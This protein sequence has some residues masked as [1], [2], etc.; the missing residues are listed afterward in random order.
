MLNGAMGI[1]FCDA[2]LAAVSPATKE[3][4]S[5]NGVEVIALLDHGPQHDGA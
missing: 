1:I 4:R 3:K 5:N 2:M